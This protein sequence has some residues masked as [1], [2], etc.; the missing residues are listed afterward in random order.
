[1]SRTVILIAVLA[2]ALGLT[3]YACWHLWRIAPH[4]WKLAVTGLFLLWMAS[5]FAGFAYMERVPVKA[6][7][8]LYEVGNTWM[9]AFLYL[10]I[11][12]LV[13]DV[14]SLC[15]ILPKTFLKESTPGLLTVLGAVAVILVLGN[16][17]YH[18]K[19]REELVI[20]TDKPLEKTLT[21]VLASDL[22]VGY[23]N[24]KA[25]LARWV[26]LVNAE[27]PDLVLF[28]GDIIDRSLRPVLEGRYGEEFLRIK[29][30]VLAVLGNHE[31]YGD[32]ERAERPFPSGPGRLAR[33]RRR[34]GRIHPRAGPPTLPPGGGRGGRHRFPVQ[35]PYAPRTGLARILGHRCTLR[36][37]LGALSKGKDAVLHLFRPGSLGGQGPGGHKVGVP[38]AQ[39]T[40]MERSRY[41]T[42]KISRRPMIISAIPVIFRTSGKAA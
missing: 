6:A 26:D 16:I 12:F 40:R 28:G 14:A 10:L 11:I 1:M 23:H 27:N 38:G 3:G 34:P 42:G 37:S 39:T 41:R 35:R 9:I 30:P 20:T 17:H 4:G 29:A 31:Y 22:H 2:F 21:I 32:I 25:E 8:V 36:E 24:R 5:M 15:H 18:H 7:T 13:T 33:P 19:Y